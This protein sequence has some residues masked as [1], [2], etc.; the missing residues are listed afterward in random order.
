MI[1]RKLNKQEHMSILTPKN[2]I[3]L[4][5]HLSSKKEG[6]YVEKYT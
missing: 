2:I 4:Q 3:F 5:Y 1:F 6:E